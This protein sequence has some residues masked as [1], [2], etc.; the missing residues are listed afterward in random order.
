MGKAEVVV[1][2]KLIANELIYFWV[3]DAFRNFRIAE[4]WFTQ[5]VEP[6]SLS[7]FCILADV[8]GEVGFDIFQLIDELVGI[9]YG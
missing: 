2:A 5:S 1:Y 8:Y 7:I 4:V 3:F 9:G 6:S